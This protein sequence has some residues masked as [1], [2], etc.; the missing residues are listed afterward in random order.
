MWILETPGLFLEGKKLWLKPGKEYLFGRIEKDKKREWLI[1]H[2]TVSRKHFL[3]KVAPVPDGEVS[4]VHAR[5]KITLQDT[6]KAGTTV[7]GELVK[8]ATVEL[9]NAIN[10]IRP[11]SNPDVITISWWPCNITF[12][13]DKKTFN[14]S[15]F[16]ARQNMLQELDI[17]VVSEYLTGHTTHLVAK[18]RNT[19]KGLQALL[20]GRHIVVDEY[21]QVLRMVTFPKDAYEI[22][23]DGVSELE[24][25][26]DGKWPDTLQYLPPKGREPTEQ[27]DEAYRPNPA[28]RKM[29]DKHT[30]FF[31]TQSQYD[32]LL[33]VVT[34]GHGKALMFET[35]ENVTSVDEGYKFVQNATGSAGKAVIVQSN[36]DGDESIWLTD[37]IE[38]LSLRCSQASANQSDILDA[39]LVVNTAKLRKP[40]TGSSQPKTQP[41]SHKRAAVSRNSSAKET[42]YTNRVA[43]TDQSQRDQ[44]Q[45]SSAIL[46]SETT[47]AQRP[48]NQE[49]QPQVA[50]SLDE[51]D[52]NPRPKKRTRTEH[53][54]RTLQKFD[55]E[56]DPDAIQAYDEE[57]E[58]SVDDVRN[59]F[60]DHD[61]SQFSASI[62]SR[63]EGEDYPHVKTEQTQ[64]LTS[65]ST[66]I[67]HTQH[68]DDDMDELLP[69]VAAMREEMEKEE[70]AA[71]PLRS[72]LAKPQA[73]DKTKPKKVR[74]NVR[75]T[76]RAQREAEDEA[77]RQQRKRYEEL[78]AEDVGKTG[79][80]NLALI[81][82]VSMPV[83]QKPQNE[84][85]GEQWKPEWDGRKNFKK[86]KRARDKFVTTTTDRPDHETNVIP[87]VTVIMQSRG[88]GNPVWIRAAD[89]QPNPNQSEESSQ[90]TSQR[91]KHRSQASQP[92]RVQKVGPDSDFED[93][94]IS[95]ATIRLQQEA[96]SVLDHPVDIEEPRQTRNSDMQTQTSTSTNTARGAGSKRLASSTFSSRFAPDKRQRTHTSDIATQSSASTSTEDPLKFKFIKRNRNKDRQPS[97]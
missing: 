34:T 67:R 83:R 50:Q 2:K 70:A 86:F 3:L 33:P 23:V 58:V 1:Q 5:S 37:Y 25:D 97:E 18:K 42:K 80:A 92:R 95:P 68:F 81:K 4:Q 71:R 74:I 51:Q 8:A 6:S 29:F 15:A 62:R 60:E 30:F 77:E 31:F 56:F 53:V 78:Q 19:S 27:P 90:T 48:P 38:E 39:I 14:Q 75:E 21:V 94:H 96:N 84:Y 22:E 65:Q 49:T 87:S 66:S 55:D 12:T 61:R 41:A 13:L 54:K 9:R 36:T 7:D 11:G 35:T 59:T 32:T 57:D 46:S 40:I 24:L 76:I 10:T 20:E 45:S 44:S 91:S 17:R 63:P 85:R 79:P 16:K 88:L 72:A 43:T 28:R 52:D 89:V 93:E 47:A 82:P 26:F 64:P 73:K 69:G